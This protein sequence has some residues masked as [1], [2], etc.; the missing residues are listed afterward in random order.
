MAKIKKLGLAWYMY[1]NHV[2]IVPMMT[3]MFV[4]QS[5]EGGCVW[6]LWTGVFVLVH[7]YFNVSQMMMNADEWWWWENEEN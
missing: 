3:T 6:W 7:T 2:S 4:V 1:N 5:R